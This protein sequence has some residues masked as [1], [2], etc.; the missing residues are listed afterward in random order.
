MDKSKNS[1]IKAISVYLNKAF[2]KGKK[3]FVF[4]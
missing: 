2:N 4:A 1:I 3:A